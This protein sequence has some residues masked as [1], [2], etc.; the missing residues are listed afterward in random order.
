[1]PA[2][3]LTLPDAM[4]TGDAPRLNPSGAVP[5]NVQPGQRLTALGMQRNNA[6]LFISMSIINAASRRDALAMISGRETA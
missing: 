3:G 4:V 1:M 2:V 6:R 5:R